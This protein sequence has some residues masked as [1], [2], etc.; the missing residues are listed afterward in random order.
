M[1]LSY[2]TYKSI[3][4]TIATIAVLISI[5]P[6]SLITIFAV[7]GSIRLLLELVTIFIEQKILK[8]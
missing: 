2:K 7:A 6:S 5:R 1:K 4:F 8:K 3:I